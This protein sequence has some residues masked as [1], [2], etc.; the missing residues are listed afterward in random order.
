MPERDNKGTTQKSQS[1][2]GNEQGKPATVLPAGSQARQSAQPMPKSPDIWES[3]T[4]GK[5][6]TI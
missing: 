4:P 3:F 1:K 2:L 6:K 5:G